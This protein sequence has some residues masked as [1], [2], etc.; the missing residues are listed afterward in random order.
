MLSVGVGHALDADLNA[1]A[2]DTA[3][4]PPCPLLMRSDLAPSWPRIIMTAFADDTVVEHVRRAVYGHDVLLMLYPEVIDTF[5]LAEPPARPALPLQ[6]HRH[7][8]T[9]SN[10]EP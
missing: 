3:A 5:T 1:L 6:R 10:R 2:A 9:A 7:P 4:P 8:R